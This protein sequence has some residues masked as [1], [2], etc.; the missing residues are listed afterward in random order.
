MKVFL[1]PALRYVSTE[2]WTAAV[3]AV[4][5]AVFVAIGWIQLRQSKLADR[6]THY[7]EENI[8]WIFLQ[9]EQEFVALRDSLRQAQRYPQKINTEALRQD[10]EIFVSRVLIVQSVQIDPVAAPLP[11]HADALSLI[12]QFVERADPLLSEESAIALHP[13]MIDR[14]LRDM[15]LLVEPLHGMSLVTTEF[16][17][18]A[19]NQRNAATRQQVLVSI[20]LTVFQG[21]LTMVFA[22]FLI[23]KVWSLE[24]RGLEL[25][26]ARDEILRL[27]GVLEERVRQRTAQLE[28]ANHELEAFSYSVSHDLRSPL[29]SIDGF[30]HLLE[31][32]IGE[33][34]GEKQT[35]YLKRIRNGVR[36]MGELIDGLLSL[37]QLSRDKLHFNKVDLAV[38][39]RRIEKDCRERDP[40]RQAQFLIQDTL[41]VRGDQRLLSVL[42]QNLLGNAW[43]FT[44]RSE[45]TRIEI[46]SQPGKAGEAG[47]T[48]YFIKDNGAGFD[49][50]YAFGTFERLHS[51]AD[52]AGTGIG[53]ATVKR[54]V[55]RHGGRVWAEGK[56]GEGAVFFFSLR[57]PRAAK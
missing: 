57:A 39:A 51:P 15:E 37:A 33:K 27:N 12:R 25:G 43:K 18:N 20:A 46:G 4:L 38:I 50:A 2:R 31:R 53:L 22:V 9:L 44:S 52:F 19:V 21:L 13:D 14:L 16:M 55:D 10:Y 7:T 56:E 40:D 8:S 48:V 17:D 30:S 23:R 3:T 35:H 47:E 54:V 6:T 28:A 29:K 41:P 11:E 32:S 49:M 34:A 36:Q 42:L 5:I 24:K 1:R 45:L 26:V